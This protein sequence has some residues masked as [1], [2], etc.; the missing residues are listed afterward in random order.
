MKIKK[1]ESKKL[2]LTNNGDL[3]LFFIGVGSAFTR[4]QYQTNLLVIKGDDHL[5]IDCGTKCNQALFELGLQITDINNF[6]IT[7]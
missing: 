6:L 2:K 1:F 3:V 4:R 5:L 7:H